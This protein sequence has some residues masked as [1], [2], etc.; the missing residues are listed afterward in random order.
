MIYILAVCVLSG[1]WSS[2]EILS[3]YKDDPFK[4]LFTSEYC[5]LFI[6]FNVVLSYACY[7][8]ISAFWSDELISTFGKR[9]DFATLCIAAFGAPL[10]FRSRLFDIRSDD[11]TVQVGPGFLLDEFLRIVDRQIDRGRALFRLDFVTEKMAGID[12]EKA[13]KACQLLT[14]SSLQRLSDKEKEA[15]FQKVTEISKDESRDAE[16]KGYAL[17]FVILD[18]VGEKFA[19][20]LAE[21]L[22]EAQNRSR[23]SLNSGA[24]VEE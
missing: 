17:G 8:A 3:R 6:A 4:V 21:K 23:E 16:Q 18:F 2:I 19:V 10:F 14:V 12:F 13:H 7:S 20:R 5:F 11:R 24:V 22:R 9:S 15:F 1:L